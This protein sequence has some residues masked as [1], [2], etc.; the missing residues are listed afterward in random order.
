MKKVIQCSCFS[1]ATI[2]LISTNLSAYNIVGTNVPC[3]THSD[4]QKKLN[5]H[6]FCD[7]FKCQIV[8]NH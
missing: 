2:L 4:C 1:L 8:G 3:V 7:N 6:T 5:P